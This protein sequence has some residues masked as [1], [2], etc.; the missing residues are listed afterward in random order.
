[1]LSLSRII[2]RSPSCFVT[3]PGKDLFLS[4]LD[5]VVDHSG[6]CR[7]A[8]RRRGLRKRTSQMPGHPRHERGLRDD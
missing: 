1:M 8:A 6:C 7:T 4:L 2:R 5:T 3:F